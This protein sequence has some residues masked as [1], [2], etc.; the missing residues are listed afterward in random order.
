M[1]PTDEDNNKPRFFF[2]TDGKTWIPIQSISFAFEDSCSDEA[3]K[4]EPLEIV[5]RKG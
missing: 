5:P 2:T 1:G 3:W 4:K